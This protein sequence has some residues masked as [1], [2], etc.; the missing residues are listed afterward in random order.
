MSVAD[1]PGMDVRFAQDVGFT[2]IEDGRLPTNG[3]TEAPLDAHIEVGRALGPE[4]RRV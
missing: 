2:A 1:E 3:L 4:V